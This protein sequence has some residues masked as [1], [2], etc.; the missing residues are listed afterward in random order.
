MLH[1]E[2]LHCNPGNLRVELVGS[3]TCCL[4]NFS[5]AFIHEDII[6]RLVGEHWICPIRDTRS[7]CQRRQSYL[8][9]LYRHG[10]ESEL[11]WWGVCRDCLHLAIGTVHEEKASRCLILRSKENHF[12]P[13][14]LVYQRQRGPLVKWLLDV[15][16]LVVVEQS[17]HLFVLLLG[18][19]F[20]WNS[21]TGLQEC[22][23]H[24]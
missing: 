23:N 7:S 10:I 9:A 19:R 8:A 6:I 16:L 20:G 12:E 22:K 13:L 1:H 4:R 18:E 21:H 3:S 24:Q 2:L 17:H 15:W 11:H 14:R 5:V